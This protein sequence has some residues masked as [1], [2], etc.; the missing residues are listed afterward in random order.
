MANFEQFANR[1]LRLEGGFVNN[2]SDKGG[3]TKYG[4]ILST[5]KQYGYD[6]DRDGD[7]DVEDLKKITTDDAKQIAKKIFW[8]FFKAD[9][10]KNQSVA[11]II[12]DWAYNS[13]R[14]VAAKKVQQILKVPVDGDFGRITLQAINKA[15]QAS[16][17][18][19]I[20]ASRAQYYQKIVENNPSQLI[21]LRGWMNRLNDFFFI[22]DKSNCFHN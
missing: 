2:P 17:F 18:E 1:L 4:V 11:E 5:W 14:V 15:N 3:P 7:I 13:G 9:Q 10:I 16:L 20:K 6:K 21:F 12:V 22:I 8:D 19:A